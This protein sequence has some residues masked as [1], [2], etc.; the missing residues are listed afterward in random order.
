MRFILLSTISLMLS[1]NTITLCMFDRRPVIHPL[2]FRGA[3]KDNPCHPLY[4]RP[5]QHT[6]DTTPI[7]TRF[8]NAIKR[9]RHQKSD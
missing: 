1:I 3:T 6:S 9:M 5:K 7:V 8:K 4:Q 2:M